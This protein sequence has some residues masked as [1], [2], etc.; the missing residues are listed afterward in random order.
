MNKNHCQLKNELLPYFYIS[1]V[2]PSTSQ[3]NH[4]ILYVRH[5]IFDLYNYNKMINELKSNNIFYKEY[6]EGCITIR[7]LCDKPDSLNLLNLILLKYID[8][9][10]KYNF[11]NDISDMIG[12]YIYRLKQNSIFNVD[13]MNN[14]KN[15]TIYSKYEPFNDSI[16]KIL[17]KELKDEKPKII[18]NKLIVKYRPEIMKDLERFIDKCLYTDLIRIKNIEYDIEYLEELYVSN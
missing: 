10:Y 9:S 5:N 12:N 14:Q 2:I 15:I 1:N 17:H 13:I 16:I 8:F 11:S 18:D 4:V 6:N 3:N 7:H